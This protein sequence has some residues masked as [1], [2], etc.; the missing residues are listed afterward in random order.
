M[1]I[2]TFETTT[3]STLRKSVGLKCYKL[4]YYLFLHNKNYIIF[5]LIVKHHLVKIILGVIMKIAT[6][7]FAYGKVVKGNQFFNRKKEITELS[8]DILNHQN[9]ILYAPRRYGKTSLILKTFD[10]LEKKHKNFIGLYIDFYNVNSVEKFI[11]I[12]SNQYAEKARLSLEKILSLLK[13]V[14]SGVTPGITLDKDGNPKIELSILQNQ[15]TKAFE[16]VMKLPQRLASEKKIVAVFF[17]E[18]QEVI[19]LNGFEFQKKL[20]SIIQHHNQVSYIFC[21]SKHHLLKD[22]FNNV[23]NPLYKS[24]KT[25]SLDV[26]PETEYSYFITNRFKK[27][28]K[29]FTLNDA[30]NIYKLAGTIPYNIQLLCNEVYNLML[31]NSGVP[32]KNLIRFGYQNIIESKNE[33]F[34]VLYDKLS[35]SVKLALEILINYEGKNLFHKEV[36]SKYKIASST[37]RKAL[38][39]LLE[40]GIIYS[41]N[42]IYYFYDI[43]FKEWI[44]KK[45]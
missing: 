6:N 8:T 11:S 45:L 40:E 26:I 41:Q 5:H 15:K 16:D 25:K 19:T 18:F 34:L 37:L 29:N 17:D 1:I 12:M 14:I 20:R 33:E 13:N 32:I 28:N 22:I 4:L 31:I 38:N 30:K 36:L 3:W 23:N 24:G 21:G 42:K 7:P 27:L 43:F 10:E 35:N 39:K 2:I 9:V 44:A